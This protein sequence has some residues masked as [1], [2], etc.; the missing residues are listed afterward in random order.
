MSLAI[1]V[2]LGGTKI[3][4]GVVDEHG[5]I[6]AQQRVATPTDSADAVVAAL[7]ALISDLATEHAVTAACV[8]APG[9]VD[10]ARSKVLFAPNLPMRDLPLR[11]LLESAVGITVVIENDANA[12]A[13][14]EARFGAARN[15]RNLVALTIGTGL[16]CGIVIERNLVRGA[17]GVAAEAG[18]VT[19]QP[20]GLAC[21]CGQLGCWEQ[22]ASGTA[23]V[24]I[25]K[26]MA[27]RSAA[28]AGMLLGFGDGTVDGIQGAHITAAA[29][30][31]CPVATAA[32]DQLGENLG[33]GM[34]SVS[35]LIDP[36]KY[37]LGGGVSSAGELLLAPTRTAFAAHLTARGHRPVPE[38]VAAEMGN[39]AG[40]VGAADLARVA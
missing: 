9:L 18:H 33:R 17:F 10:Y 7:A 4:A 8:A 31:G 25:A 11:Q 3:A 39:D 35:A 37:V 15:A 16:G 26:E 24:R 28:Q 21:G 2:D 5:S 40:L 38:I 13:W 19:F 14:A 22:Y 30:A 32:F 1:G 29:H 23:L 27:S 6:I 20:D 12:A 34:A 36:F